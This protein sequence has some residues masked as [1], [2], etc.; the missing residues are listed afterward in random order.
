MSDWILLRGLTRETR[1]WGGFEAALFAHGLVGPG[2]RVV[3]IDLPGNGT[4][5]EREV[6]RSVIAMMDFVR[7]RAVAL[8]V[9]F[10]CRVLAM[11]LGAMV[12]AA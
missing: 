11:S 7:E 8:G 6:S 3:F 10:P 1:H 5:H 9:R 12:A 2:E 4:E